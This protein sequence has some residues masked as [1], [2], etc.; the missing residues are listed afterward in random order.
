MS[1]FPSR[2]ANF[3]RYLMVEVNASVSFQV[4]PR[5]GRPGKRA[6]GRLMMGNKTNAE[7]RKRTQRNARTITN[8]INLN[9]VKRRSVTRNRPCKR[10][11]PPHLLVGDFGSGDTRQSL[12]CQTVP[13]H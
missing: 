10:E 3:P 2:S 1:N 7:E 4:R 12:V 6:G 9:F 13:Q 11:P 8:T 5:A